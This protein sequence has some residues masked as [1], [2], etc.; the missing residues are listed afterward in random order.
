MTPLFR[1]SHKIHVRHEGYSSSMVAFI[2]VDE[3]DH[4]QSVFVSPSLALLCRLHGS[5]SRG[6][7]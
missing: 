7:L 1:S 2:M 6:C 4:W 5:R 3:T